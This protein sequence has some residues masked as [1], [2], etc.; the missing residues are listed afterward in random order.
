MPFI[1][2][3]DR[4]QLFYR[5]AGAGKPVVFVSSAWLSSR[6]WEF[7]FPHLVAGGRRCIAYDRR[8]HARS[9]WPWD[10]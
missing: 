7:Q 2:T 8:G 1:E 5:D 9:D 6:M 4:T 10:G 3:N